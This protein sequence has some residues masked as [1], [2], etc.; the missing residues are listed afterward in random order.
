MTLVSVVV[1]SWNDAVM[2]RVCLAALA[3]QS[4]PADEIIVVDNGSTDDTAAVARDAGAT[5]VTE[6]RR[7]VWPA[8]IAGFDAASGEIIARLDA[9]SVPPPDWL[10]RVEA[11]LTASGAPHESGTPSAVTGPGGFY[12]GNRFTRWVGEHVYIAGYFWFVGLLLGHPP[13]FGSNFALRRTVW[14]SLR[15][16]LDPALERIHDDL[17]LSFLLEPDVAVAYDP[18]LRVGVSAR[19]FSSLRGLGRRVGWA[20]LGLWHNRGRTRWFTVRDRRRGNTTREGRG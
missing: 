15:P 9:D 10:A 20:A 18:A 8:T 11:T 3:A 5:V 19:P 7:G 13:L 12:G 4:R 2:L 1:P 6:P 17:Q 14:T 16:H